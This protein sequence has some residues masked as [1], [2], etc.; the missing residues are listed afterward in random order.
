MMRI[1]KIGISSLVVTIALFT[2]APGIAAE[3][4]NIFQDLWERIV[5]SQGQEKPRSVRGGICPV[6]P[7][8]NTVV[9]SDRPFFMWRDSAQT[10][11][12]Y[13][14]NLVSSRQTPLWSKSVTE[15]QTSIRYDGEPLREG[16]YTWEVVTPLGVKQQTPFYVMG[17]VERDA[18][19]KTFAEFDSLKGN[20][21]ILQRMAVL[22]KE[23]LLGDAVAEL[24]EVEGEDVQKMRSDFVKLVC[25]PSPRPKNQ[26]QNNK[27]QIQPQ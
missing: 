20:D 18:L 14:G 16:E 5:R 22:E 7:G 1:Q 6:I 19:K 23:G 24:A 21:R 10:V 15:S 26:I 11:L 17:Q 27:P 2:S 13:P 9:G 12:L 3:K 4:K 25:E 8:L